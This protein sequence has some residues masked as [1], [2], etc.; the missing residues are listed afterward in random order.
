VP[1]FAILG[2]ICLIGFFHA[3]FIKLVSIPALTLIPGIQKPA[4]ILAP[5]NS[6]MLSISTGAIL[7][8]LI[9]G[10]VYGL[11]L[12]ITRKAVDRISAT[13]GCGYTGSSPKLQYTATSFVKSYTEIASPLLRIKTT[14]SAIKGLFP[15]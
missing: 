6:T 8:V 5:V 9:C 1:Q 3:P 10:A 7:I 14:M 4:E 2:I 12:F 13:W 15:E 11:K